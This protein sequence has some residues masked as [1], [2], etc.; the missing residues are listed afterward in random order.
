MSKVQS[1]LIER[2][3]YPDIYKAIEKIKRLGFN[4]DHGIDIKEHHW[5]FRQFDPDQN[6]KHSTKVLS[7]KESKGI[8]FIIEY[9]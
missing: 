2:S 7:G 8:K 5:R 4:I 3:V 6:K 1:V 9:G